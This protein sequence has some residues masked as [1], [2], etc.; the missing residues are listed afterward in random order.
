MAEP[1]NRDSDLAAD[2]P[3]RARAAGYWWCAILRHLKYLERKCGGSGSIRI[4]TN[5]PDPYRYLFIVNT[6]HRLILIIATSVEEPNTLN[7]HPD[8]EFWLNLD[9]VPGL[10]F[11]C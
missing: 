11:Q 1:G 8:P 9:L 10:C 2:R 4:L 5:L 6:E 3:P 7:F